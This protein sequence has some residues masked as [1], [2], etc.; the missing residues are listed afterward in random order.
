MREKREIGDIYS[1]PSLKGRKYI[2]LE[3][4]VVL[5]ASYVAQNNQDV[6][7]RWFEGCEVHHIDYDYTNDVPENLV[8]VTPEEHRLLH[9]I[10]IIAYKD[11][12]KIGVFKSMKEAGNELGLIPGYISRY[13]KTGRPADDDERY[14]FETVDLAEKVRMFKPFVEQLRKREL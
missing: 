7:G 9:S 1:T 2:K 8:C 13:L 14:S 10:P 3:S 6:C 5:Y 11:G 4:G 12:K